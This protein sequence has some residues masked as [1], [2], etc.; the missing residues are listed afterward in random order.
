GGYLP[1]GRLVAP[2]STPTT[3]PRENSVLAIYQDIG[4]GEQILIKSDGFWPEMLYA[5]VHKPLVWTNLSGSSQ[6]LNFV[7]FPV[8][9][10]TIPPGYQ[11]VWIPPG[12]LVSY[13]STSGFRGAVLV[14]APTPIQIPR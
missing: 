1:A 2:P 5:A 14:S 7:D 6:T 13:R 9:P 10:V 12:G 3:V 8:R 4:T 11:Y